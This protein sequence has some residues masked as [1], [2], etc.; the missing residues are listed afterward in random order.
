MAGLQAGEPTPGPTPSS[1]NSNIP[2]FPEYFGGIV[3]SILAQ[4]VFYAFFL[5]FVIKLVKWGGRGYLMV[6]VKFYKSKEIVVANYDPEVDGKVSV[7]WHGQFKSTVTKVFRDWCWPPVPVSTTPFQ[8]W[9]SKQAEKLDNIFDDI[10]FTEY[11]SPMEDLSP[12]V[13]ELDNFLS[14]LSE[15][16]DIIMYGKTRLGWMGAG[17]EAIEGI[18]KIRDDLSSARERL[19]SICTND[20]WSESSQR[21]HREFQLTA[22]SH[23]PNMLRLVAAYGKSIPLSSGRDFISSRT[24]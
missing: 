18:R 4:A 13:S 2:Y 11:R 7:G 14:K 12:F 16:V 9:I 3:T 10:H 20:R 1:D 15:D 17:K 6:W 24:E 22:I 19:V 5:V 21:E 23:T 8:N